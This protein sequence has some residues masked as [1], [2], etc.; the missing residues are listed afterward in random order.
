MK[1]KYIVIIIL[2]LS[3]FIGTK[4]AYATQGIANFSGPNY[5]TGVT[6]C[7][8]G[9]NETGICGNYI[10]SPKVITVGGKSY[11]AYCIDPGLHMVPNTS[12]TCETTDD[13]GLVYLMEKAPLSTAGYS[14]EYSLFQLAFRMYATRKNIGNNSLTLMKAAIVRY[15]QI[16]EEDGDPYRVLAGCKP[17]QNCATDP[18]AY[19]GGNLG[20]I[21]QAW[22]LTLEAYALAPDE[23]GSDIA[24]NKESSES[25]SGSNGTLKLTAVLGEPN[26]EVVTYKVTSTQNI[27]KVTFACENCQI[28]SQSFSGISGE[29]TVRILSDPSLCKP[30][31]IKAYY[32]P[33]GVQICHTT[34]SGL[35]ADFQYLVTSFEETGLDAG[36]TSPNPNP[37]PTGEPTAVFEFEPP[38]CDDPTCCHFGGD[39]D[40][41]FID[42][43]IYN[44]CY[45]ST[46]SEASQY[47]LNDLFCYHNGLGVDHYFAKCNTDS[48]IDKNLQGSLNSYC[49]IYCT[50]RVSIDVPDPITAK[51]GR[52]FELSKSS[53]GTKSP[54][55]EGAKRCRMI[56]D[57]DKWN[58]DYISQVKKEIE[59]YNKFQR[60]KAYELMYEN[61]ISKASDAEETVTITC[62]PTAQSGTTQTCSYYKTVEGCKN[63]NA[64]NN[65]CKETTASTESVTATSKTTDDNGT[66]IA[67][68]TL[69][70][71][72]KYKKYPFSTKYNWYETKI[73]L[74]GKTGVE[75]D[76]AGKYTTTH[77]QDWSGW[78]DTLDEQ[79]ASI[80]EFNTTYNNKE[81]DGT[82]TT[83]T[84]TNCTGVTSTSPKT[85]YV[86]SR[87]YAE[88]ESHKENV[89]KIYDDYKAS[90]SS[91]N[92]EFN[93]AAQTA[94]S[95]E[96]KL[97]QCD[98]FF[99]SDAA[100][101]ENVY[102][103][104][105]E[106]EGFEY[107]QVYK[108]DYGKL[109]SETTIIPFKNTPGC[110]V[111]GPILGPS[112]AGDPDALESP[113]Y[114]QYYGDGN[115]FMHDFKATTLVWDSNGSGYRDFLDGVYYADKKL[116]QDA[117]YISKCSWDE[118]DKIIYTLIPRG[119]A[120]EEKNFNYTMGTHQY[121]VFLSTLAG[122]YDTRWLIKNL[123]TNG[124]FDEIFQNST[125]CSSKQYTDKDGMLHCGLEVEN[126]LITV[127]TCNT[128]KTIVDPDE[129]PDPEPGDNG[130]VLKFKIVDPAHVFPSCNSFDSCGFGYNWFEGTN[131]PETQKNIEQKGAKNST[132]APENMSYSFTFTPKDLKHIKN[133][134][135]YREENNRG[136][137][138]D[139]EL[140]CQC[141]DVVE[142]CNPVG[143][144]QVCKRVD[145]CKKCLSS[146]LTNLYNG[147]IKYGG[148]TYKVT[149]SKGSINTIRDT[150]IHWAGV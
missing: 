36:G 87:N 75:I 112:T 117:K 54:Y 106:L 80:T 34:N 45:D 39:I 89:P 78:S 145:S 74:G 122:T 81:I 72:L 61:A 142:E 63:P 5:S 19:L 147:E 48:F 102:K 137:Y 22:Q 86:C 70:V 110:E 57:Y 138:S 150:K 96:D 83:A 49:S 25:A 8:T 114:S 50:E 16:M 15:N 119:E 24:G 32:N 42:G 131:G 56:I 140:G 133:Y 40:P 143:E 109:K 128:E 129:C 84:S 43:D 46:H 125:A 104:A 14:Y 37:N 100:K 60:A 123:G 23:F 126:E 44:C 134:N 10:D 88:V 92:S 38:Y 82:S 52:Y 53:K 26:S 29:I 77:T 62:T 51:S 4:D 69:T 95:T 101:A 58:S 13:A 21:D 98:N 3:L 27:E 144:T 6:W 35:S 1:K 113:Q 59:K 9:N 135:K 71:T 28:L 120:T 103:F 76:P 149:S 64:S 91:A 68:K 73:K 99:T 55:I 33:K 20:L 105:P 41:G 18:H 127:G 47:G 79:L 146:F 139:F 121:R 17:G 107:T 148:A 93:S 66:A 11:A 7:E 108:D 30:Y 65:Y 94:K 2:V 124:K 141:P 85:K 116:T 90:A 31:K 132:Y 111:E 130:S 136:G 97:T 12:Y 67:A 118:E 115:A